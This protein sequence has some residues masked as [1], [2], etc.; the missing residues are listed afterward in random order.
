MDQVL[1]FFAEYPYS[2]LFGMIF[3]EELG[4]WLP[5]PG[6]AVVVLFGVWSRQNLVEFIP[7]LLVICAATALGSSGLF[8]FSR[9]LGNMLLSRYPKILRY[10]HITQRNIDVI[11]GWMAKY[12][13]IVLIICRLI[14]GLRIISTVAAGM[15][16]V[17]YRTF[18]TAT[19]IGTVLWTV[20][21][22]SLGALL[23]REFATQIEH[24]LTLPSPRLFL[25][26][27]AWLVVSWLV[28]VKL[29]APRLRRHFDF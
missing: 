25:I 26:L 9:W 4:I 12:G 3:I 14:F 22:Y 27:A 29:L 18:I 17:P 8:F 13:M 21:L 20:G 23:G 11:E 19:M 1:P 24:L 16:D 6:D 2:A 5:I 7:T 28:F 15:L 10:L